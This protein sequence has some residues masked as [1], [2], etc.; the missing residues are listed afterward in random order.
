[1]PAPRTPRCDALSKLPALG[2]AHAD[3]SPDASGLTAVVTL[4]PCNHTG[5]TGPCSEA[6]LE[7]G[8]ER[9]VYA[10]SDPGHRSG[11]GAERLRDGGVER[12]SR[13][14]SPTRPRSSCTCG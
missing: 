10:I 4:E 9:V 11:G 2:R 14:C 3:G 1:M 13:A 7:A 8:I 12:R 6:L 5:R